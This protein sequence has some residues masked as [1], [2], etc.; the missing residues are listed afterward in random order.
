[1][2]VALLILAGITLSGCVAYVPNR[3]YDSYNSYNPYHHHHHYH[4]HHGW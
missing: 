2:K 3:P 4:R 1:M